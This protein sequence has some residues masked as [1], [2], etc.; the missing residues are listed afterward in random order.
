MTALPMPLR[1]AAAGVRWWVRSMSGEAAWDDY[2][3]SC[4]RHGQTPVDRRTFERA[5]DH[6]REH[7]ARG[8]CC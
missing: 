1:R 5:R 3:A 7:A 2:L 8:R 6:Q 4:A